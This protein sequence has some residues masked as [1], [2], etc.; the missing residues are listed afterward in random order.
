MTAEAPMREYM[1]KVPFRGLSLA[2]MLAVCL[3]AACKNATEPRTRAGSIRGTV[4]SVPAPDG[5]A[6]RS[7]SIAW[8]DSLLA[9]SDAS[10]A[11]A[12]SPLSEGTY[13]L[14]CSASGYRDT[15]MQV[16]IE[17]GKTT[18]LDFYLT[19]DFSSGRI[20]GEFQDQDLFNDSLKTN[21]AMA[22]WDAKTVFDAATGATIQFKTM[23]HEV[24]ERRV[25]L[26]DSLL[27]VADGWGQ[28]TFK[29]RTGT[30]SLT[31]SCEGYENVTQTVRVEPNGRHYVNFFLPVKH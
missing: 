21:P 23:Q 6:I 19:P 16:V 18:V 25:M 12:V 22:G 13:R 30:Y 1:R 24:A 17:G 15:T 29:I 27:A 4:R 5:A 10:G 28:Y 8:E 2:F 7:A 11:Y 3:W 26:G 31:G 14:T 9:V 20:F